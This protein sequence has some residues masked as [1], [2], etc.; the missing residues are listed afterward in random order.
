MVEDSLDSA[1]PVYQTTC[2]ADTHTHP[3]PGLRTNITLLHHQARKADLPCDGD[4]PFC[5]EARLARKTAHMCR[6]TDQA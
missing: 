2:D 3:L 6:E 1:P 4:A 5:P